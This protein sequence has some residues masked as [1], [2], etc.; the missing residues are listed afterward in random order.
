[1]HDEMDEKRLYVTL[2]IHARH[3]NNLGLFLMQNDVKTT[4][5]RLTNSGWMDG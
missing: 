5:K 3:E 1:M 2:Y 4:H